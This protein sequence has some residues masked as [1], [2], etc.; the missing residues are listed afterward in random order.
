MASLKTIASRIQDLYY[1]DF[2]TTNRFFDI[3]DFMTWLA[4]AYSATLNALYQQMRSENK[5]KEGFANVE[6]SPAWLHSEVLEIKKK[7]NGDLAAATTQPVFSFDFD[8]RVDSLQDVFSEGCPTCR[9]RKLSLDER[10][11]RSAIPPSSYVFYFL[12]NPKEILFWGAKE[13]DKVSVQYVPKVDGSDENCLL[14]DN[15]L[16]VDLVLKRMYEARTGTIIDKVN[17][18]NPVNK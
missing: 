11:F 8:G 2:A 1:Q 9:H 18:N 14:S 15:I 7:D 6:I 10:K 4:L 16:P 5:A 12:N 17:D 13:N 3:D